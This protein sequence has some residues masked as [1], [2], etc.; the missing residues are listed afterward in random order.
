M[1][2]TADTTDTVQS[3]SAKPRHIAGRRMG[4]CF[5]HTPPQHTLFHNSV[6]K[7][8]HIELPFIRPVLEICRSRL[9]RLIPR[10]RHGM[11]CVGVSV[12]N[13]Y[14]NVGVVSSI[15]FSRR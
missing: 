6:P 7:E 4:S 13:R 9:V 15:A 5:S 3:I 1:Y 8:D 11:F 14:G 12:I 2:S 10:H